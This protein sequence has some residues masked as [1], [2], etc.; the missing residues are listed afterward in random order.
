MTDLETT[1]I[2]NQQNISNSKIATLPPA[3]DFIRITELKNGILEAEG[4]LRVGE[5]TK[6]IETIVYK[7]GNTLTTNLVL[8]CNDWNIVRID[9]LNRWLELELTIEIV[10]ES[11]DGAS[12]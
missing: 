3:F 4:R 1:D 11:P 12:I 10:I 7:K 9:G 8:N 2:C 6:K 5:V